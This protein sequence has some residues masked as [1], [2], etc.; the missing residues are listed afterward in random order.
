M[1]GER[2]RYSRRK[3]VPNRV[4]TANRCSAVVANLLAAP[5]ARGD[6]QYASSALDVT[7]GPSR[8]FGFFP[9][10]PLRSLPPAA[11]QPWPLKSQRIT[12]R[13]TSD[14]AFQLSRPGY[15]QRDEAE[16]FV[17][18]SR[19]VSRLRIRRWRGDGR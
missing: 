15:V 13:Q 4:T 7:S 3:G 12:Q 8:F 17:I 9:L 2:L 10:S 18:G 11:F 16:K 5:V 6:P 14:A 19:F 1:S